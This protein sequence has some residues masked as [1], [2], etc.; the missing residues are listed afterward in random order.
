MTRDGLNEVKTSLREDR[1]AD[2]KA[3]DRRLEASSDDPAAAGA[4][5][6]AALGL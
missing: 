4:A 2:D 6:L 3:L 1:D 5:L